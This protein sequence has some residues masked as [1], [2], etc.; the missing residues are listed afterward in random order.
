[1]LCKMLYSSIYL[2]VH[3]LTTTQRVRVGGGIYTVPSSILLHGGEFVHVHHYSCAPPSHLP[4]K[5]AVLSQSHG[6]PVRARCSP[7][8]RAFLRL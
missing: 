7:T 8:G 3:S 2:F 1:M 6:G 5:E 4:H